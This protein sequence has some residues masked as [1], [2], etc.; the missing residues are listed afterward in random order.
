[1]AATDILRARVDPQ[2]A[3]RVERW[4]KAHG[5]DVSETIRTA[6]QE[7][8]DK[9]ERERRVREA[10]A[11]FDESRRLGLFD[12]PRPGEAWKAGGFR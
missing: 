5:T 12:P 2:F 4:A 1:M 9:D 11:H 3:R 10:L 8:L 6:L 7:L